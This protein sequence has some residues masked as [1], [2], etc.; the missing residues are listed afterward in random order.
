MFKLSDTNSATRI[1]STQPQE[2]G[3]FGRSVVADDDELIFI[4]DPYA[5]V[6]LCCVSEVRNENHQP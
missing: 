4:L 2:K 6:T 5:A 3:Y 1:T